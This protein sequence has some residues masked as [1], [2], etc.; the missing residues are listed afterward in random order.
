[1]LHTSFF[2]LHG[3]CSAYLLPQILNLVRNVRRVYDFGNMLDGFF[4][5]GQKLLRNLRKQS[6]RKTLLVRSQSLF[7]ILLLFVQNL[8]PLFLLAPVAR[9]QENAPTISN[10]SISFDQE[11]HSFRFVGDLNRSTEY[12]LSYD[13]TDPETAPNGAKGLL[14]PSDASLNQLGR[15]SAEVFAGTCSEKDCVQH[16]VVT[17]ALEFPETS[18]TIS[19]EMRDGDLWFQQGSMFTIAEVE[20]GKTYT[21]PQ[22]ANVKLVFTKLPEQPGSLSFKQITLSSE[23][24]QKLNAASSIAYD[25]T[26]SMPNESFEY[27][28]SLP[29]PE[30]LESEKSDELTIV[31]A[32]SQ[33]TL[34]Q[35]ET[36]ESSKLSI[37]E[38]NTL[39]VK[40]LNH[41]TVFVVV[42]DSV[43]TPYPGS[44]PSLGFAANSTKEFGDHIRFT[45]TD[46]KLST[47]QVTMTNWAC[48]N[49]FTFTGGTWVANRANT[50]ACIT[51]T[52]SSYQ[53]PIT[54]NLYTVDTSGATPAVGSLISSKTIDATIPFR[55]SWDATNCTASGQ[56]PATNSPFGGQWYDPVL[57]TCVSGYN[58]DL[59][60]DLASENL[61]LP[62][63]VIV[64]IAFNTS[65][66]GYTP[67]GIVGPYNSLNMG[68]GTTGPNIGT[69]VNPDLL[70]WNTTYAGFYSDGGAGG[71][72]IFRADTN[73]SPYSPIFK[74]TM[75][76]NQPPQV[77][78]KSPTPAANSYVRGTITGRATATDDK[79]MGSYYLRFWKDGFDIAGGGTLVKGCQSAPGGSRLGTSQDV[80]CVFDSTTKPDGLY[81]FSAQFLDSDIKWGQALRPFTVDN[82]KPIVNLTSPAP[83]TTIYNSLLQD[84]VIEATDNY[85]LN[86]IVGNIYKGGSLHRS[87][88]V[89]V[90]GGASAGS[91]TI[92]LATI[93]PGGT[94][95]LEGNYSIRYNALDLA[96]NLSQTKFYDF[97]I[98]NTAPSFWVKGSAWGNAYNPASIGVGNI[99]KKVS[100][101]LFDSKKIDKVSING[102]I[103]ELS[104]ENWSDLDNVVPGIFGA[105]EGTNTLVV[106]DLAGNTTSYEFI[107]DVTPPATPTLESPINDAVVNGASLTNDW[108]D[109]LDA[110]KYIYESYHDATATSLRWNQETTAS[111][112]TATNVANSTFWWRV[113]AVD[114]VGNESPWS[115][116]WKV[117][118]DNDAPTTTLTSPTDETLTNEAITI[119]GSSAD[120]HGITNVKLYYS[121]ADEEN[122]QLIT[123][124][125]HDGTSPFAFTYDWTPPADAIYD[126]KASGTDTVGN[127]EASAYA[128]DITYDTTKPTSKITTFDLESGESIETPTFDGLIE[129]TAT[130]NLSGVEMVLLTVEY[131]AFGEDPSAK[132][133]WDDLSSSWISTQTEFEALGSTTWNYQ[134]PNVPNGVYTVTSR[135]LDK[136]GNKE[137]TYTI[138]IIYDNT[139]PE[140]ALTI[141][142]AVPDALN[143]YYRAVKPTITLTA[144]D[145][146]TLDRIEIQWNGTADGTWTTYTSPVQP[147]SEGENML[148]YRSIDSLDNISDLGMK[149][150]RYDATSPVGGPL[151]LK[152]ENVTGTTADASWNKPTD[153]SDVDKYVVRWKHE[154]GTEFGVDTG[155]DDLNHQLDRLF[156]GLWTLSVKAV[157][158]A[159]NFKEATLEF[160]VGPGSAGAGGVTGEGTGTV[161][162]ANT[163]A[164]SGFGVGG[165]GIG[166][167]NSI[168]NEIVDLDAENATTETEE[169]DP[170]Q[171]T[172]DVLGAKTCSGFWAYLPIVLLIL[173]LLG[174][175]IIEM[176]LRESLSSLNLSALAVTLAAIGIWALTRSNGC[177]ADGTM[178]GIINTWFIVLSLGLAIGV[179]VITSA[180]A[181]MSEE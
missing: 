52:G 37:I 35:A 8:S 138:D 20:L 50:D 173:Q 122:W 102:V 130:D 38:E 18:T 74:F 178:L 84:I 149:V 89:T 86:K 161:L 154:N 157:D 164:Q 141:N 17:G 6:H 19:F 5:F 113:K 176:V 147:P 118:I 7:T 90:A 174:L 67:T 40:A 24:R 72:G 115:E 34:D 41:F 71:V 16:E 94:P 92:D 60:F 137:N 30:S 163:I 135:A 177:S 139:I 121:L 123:T 9:A 124:L 29:I 181:T 171:S 95:L 51:T 44:V 120:T 43:P 1:M 155:R 33:E 65:D 166:G 21:A 128:R 146:Y 23:Q 31:Y 12:V 47:V 26:S 143:N 54:L 55:P 152:V 140:V 83:G 3:S 45:G 85:A 96:G 150:V 180:L 119:A 108:S 64:S 179:R 62:D 66:N 10:L 36:I 132:L 49:D 167:E 116:L 11:S 42:Y 107:L 133:F 170:A 109:V 162:G 98:D 59:S 136:T 27:T 99:F 88:Q 78:I 2:I 126:I 14:N 168:D 57:A 145:N 175:L 32:D 77:N 151:N 91:H 110:V 46:R 125:T 158:P 25:I 28:L 129:G 13:D 131:L 160:R 142:P 63:D 148:Y 15:F 82:T 165:F 73:W 127:I 93:M 68:L 97:T 105:V 81:I 172:G 22:D 169:V 76:G 134:L 39:T 111:Q 144:S 79:G 87:T 117:T 156:N 61:T 153:D 103:K 4:G 159:G 101:K 53:H 48:E 114:L 58:F 75:F 69:N 106:Y 112:K 100:F 80:S 104:N 56:T 70:F